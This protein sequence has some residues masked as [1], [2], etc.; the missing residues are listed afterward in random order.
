[1]KNIFLFIV[2]FCFLSSCNEKKVLP[3]TPNYVINI[4]VKGL[5]DGSKLLLNKQENNIVIM[6]DSSFSKVKK[7]L[8]VVQ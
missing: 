4:E 2:L 3:L 7:Q 6:I 5:K 1:M 8:L